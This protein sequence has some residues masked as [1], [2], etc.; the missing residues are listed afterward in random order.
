M[1]KTRKPTPKTQRDIG[2]SIKPT[3]SPQTG[4][5]NSLET[6]IDFVRGN[7]KTFRGD[8]SKPF[9]IGIKDIDEAIFY[10]FKNHISPSVY[11][12]G[13]KIN[14]PLIYSS[15]ERWKTY[16]KDGYYR[17]KNGAVMYP[18][19][20]IKR[21]NI[22]K[23]RS[24]T[25]KLDANLPNLHATSARRYNQRNSYN[26][27]DLLNNRIPS[28]EYQVVVVPDYITVEYSC[29]VQTYYMEQLN[30][31]IES[32]EYSSDSYWG[33]PNRFR[34]R[35]F[36]D[37]FSTSSTTISGEDRVSTAKFALRLRGYIIPDVMQKD[38]NTIKK[39]HS[40]S[41]ITIT[42]ETINSL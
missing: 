17:D 26:N 21:D 34:F 20:V 18:V 12:N 39:T 30:K 42:S 33:D 13:E 7:K 16:R 40:K 3:T 22:L 15:P 32:I 19:I 6:G 14:V 11:Q 37:N 35:T 24:V 2:K 25:N 10:Y 4:N 23:D 28:K 8:T 1:S 31:V 9:S 5:S 38:L 36:I 27:F 41:K 29:M